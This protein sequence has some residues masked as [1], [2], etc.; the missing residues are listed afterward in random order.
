MKT[1]ILMILGT[2]Y[3]FGSIGTIMAL[4]GEIIIQRDDFIEAKMGMEIHQGDRVSTSKNSRMQVILKDQTV[5]TIGANSSFDF[6][7]YLFD[8]STN[9]KLTFKVNRGY[10]RSLTGKIGKIAPQRFKIKTISATIGVRGTDFDGNIT[11]QKE[12]I[13]CHS[14]AIWVKFDKGGV[15]NVLSGMQL[16]I[17]HR[18]PAIK[19]PMHGLPMK[20]DKMMQH[21]KIPPNHL[22]DISTEIVKPKDLPPLPTEGTP[23][24]IKPNPPS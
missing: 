19:P 3:S 11:E 23:Q 18:P 12:T 6:K 16:N 9:S 21:P 5:I 8:E 7:E 1:V 10:F 4:K 13:K 2:L 17:A 24:L 14:G 22:S 20:N 15:K